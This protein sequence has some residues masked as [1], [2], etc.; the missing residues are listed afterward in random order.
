MTAA[1]PPVWVLDDPRA[2]TAS[3]AIGIAERLGVAFRRVPMGWNWMAP[4]VAPSD[5]ALGR[6]GSLLGLRPAGLPADQPP[7]R[8]VISAGT[9]AAAVA[10]WLRGRFRCR[11]VHCMR[12][13][14]PLRSWVS[15]LHQFDLLV[16]PDHDAPPAAANVFPTLG[17]PNRV[18]AVQLDAARCAWSERLA[19]L[20]EPRVVLLLGGPSDRWFR[21]ADMRPAL[22]Y[23]LA[24]QVAGLARDAGGCVLATTSRRTG[25]EAADAL[26]AGLGGA[27]HLLYRWGEPGDNP[28][29]GYLA[30]ADAIVVT[31]DSASMLSEACATRAPVFAALPELVTGRHRRLLNALLQAGQVR[32]FA[33]SLSP[34]SREPLN[35]AGRV[36]AEIRRRFGDL[37]A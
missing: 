22:A 11:I 33:D 20:P 18:S 36:A 6:R 14:V 5:A 34:W 8:L 10:L 35:E 37:E 1:S 30:A 16:L 2:G 21:G 23:N 28:Y 17:V 29:L 26:A 4:L 7:P 12:P 24:R 9:R 19:H 13:Q 27:M 3:Q 15:V 31:A 25:T 32:P